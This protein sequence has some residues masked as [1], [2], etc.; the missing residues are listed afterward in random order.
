M[1][2]Y[3]ADEMAGGGRGQVLAP[4][5]NRLE[6]GRY[7]YDGKT[8]QA[9]IDEPAKNNAIH[10]LVRW[11]TWEMD[12]HEASKVALSC[13]LAAQPAYPWSLR[14]SMEYEVAEGSLLVRTRVANVGEGR[15]PL[16]LGFH[17]YLYAGPGGVDT[18]RLT[19]PAE[20]HLVVDDRAIPRSTQGVG[21]T[22]LDLRAGRRLSGVP[23][24]DCFTGL[25]ALGESWEVL[26]ETPERRVG[27]WASSEFA[28]VMCFTGDT[29]EP[30]DRRRGV[31]V[32]PMTCPPNALR[33]GTGIW[34]LLPGAEREASWGIRLAG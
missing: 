7:T 27:L 5:P 14:L 34:A 10:G 23:L 16:G 1:W 21:G 19:V 29:L 6:D 31:A 18:C 28:Y 9:A 26:L 20:R 33:S 3:G 15:A 25:A 11:L 30:A 13:V 12:S 32:E 24:D 22:G 2:G 17:P 8:A 4:W